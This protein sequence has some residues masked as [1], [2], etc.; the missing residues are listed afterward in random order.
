[1]RLAVPAA[2]VALVASSPAFATGTIHC[3]GAA[4]DAPEIY[5]SVGRGVGSTIQQMSLSSG[6]Y[7][8]TTGENP[9][10]PVISQSWLDDRELKIDVVD[11]NVENYVAR[12][13]GRRAGEDR[14][15]VTHSFRGRTHAMNCTLED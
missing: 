2:L 9:T 8:F 11:H 14:Y 7:R 1:M 4:R 6:N 13:S 5:L 10:S 3:E 15:R 12:I